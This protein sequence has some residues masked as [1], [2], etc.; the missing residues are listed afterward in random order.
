MSLYCGGPTGDI[1]PVLGASHY[2]NRSKYI[3][4]KR[5]PPGCLFC[6]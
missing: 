2:E 3:S 1:V 6:M 5:Q 4:I